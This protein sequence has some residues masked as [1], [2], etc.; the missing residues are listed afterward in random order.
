MAR[1]LPQPL[2]RKEASLGMEPGKEGG[3]GKENCWKTAQLGRHEQVEPGHRWAS[4]DPLMLFEPDLAPVAWRGLGSTAHLE[5]IASILPPSHPL[6]LTFY[7]PAMVSL[8]C[9]LQLADFRKPCVLCV[10]SSA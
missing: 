2:E 6:P 7:L 4:S 5:C 8:V 1:P 9:D 3:R 10:T